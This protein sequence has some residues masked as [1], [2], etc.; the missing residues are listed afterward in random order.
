[1]NRGLFITVDGPGGTGKSTTIQ[2]TAPLLT[3]AGHT[4]H[5]TT[6]PSPNPFGATIRHM[7]NE[8]QGRSLALAVAADRFHQL[9]T[10]I[11]PHLEVGHTVLLDRYLPSTLVLQRLD[12]LSIDYLL[13]I[14][15]QLAVPDLAVIL[16]ADPDVILARLEKRGTRHRFELDPKSTLRELELYREAVPV[17]SQ[18]GYP[19]ATIDTTRLTPEGVAHAIAHAA[20]APG[21]SVNSTVPPAKLE[22][23][24]P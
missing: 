12:G 23:P 17:L 24:K 4:V 11:Q 9:D 14:N 16:L 5:T 3:A 6:Q 15:A 18:L 7:A 2:H 8:M 1:M 22:N 19:T 20:S 10:E 21:A 13:T